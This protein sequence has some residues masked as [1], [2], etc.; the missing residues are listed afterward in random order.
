MVRGRVTHVVLGVA[1]TTA[2]FLYRRLAV[3]FG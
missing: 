3:L 1:D 2:L